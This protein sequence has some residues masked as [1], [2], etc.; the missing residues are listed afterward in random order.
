VDWAAVAHPR[1][2]MQVE[3]A[4]S[5]KLQGLKSH[6]LTLLGEDV[7]V[8]LNTR[9]G[10]WAAEVPLVLWSLRTMPN[11]S[12]GFT[13]FFMVLDSQT[14]MHR[15]AVRVSLGPSLSTKH[16]RGGG[17]KDAIDQLEESRDTTVIRSARYQQALQH[18]HMRRVYP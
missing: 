18:Y 6:I 2:N 7:N 14:T 9:V 16:G 12:T 1:M 10:K 17:R 8:W 15:P 5:M 3:R 4:N 11:R 13:P